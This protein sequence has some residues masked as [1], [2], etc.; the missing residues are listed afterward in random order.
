MVCVGDF[1]LMAESVSAPRALMTP[2]VAV[3]RADP[4][5]PEY[6]RQILNCMRLDGQHCA[7]GVAPHNFDGHFEAYRL[8]EHCDCG[9]LSAGPSSTAVSA[10]YETHPNQ[11]LDARFLS[12]YVRTRGVTNTHSLGAPGRPAAIEAAHVMRN[13]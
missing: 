7:P 11:G 4:H 9:Y 2:T 10:V 3:D 12:L 1:G 6:S 8:A 5:S 13:S